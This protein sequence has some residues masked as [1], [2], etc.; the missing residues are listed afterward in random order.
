MDLQKQLKQDNELINCLWQI[1]KQAQIDKD[2]DTAL[3]RFSKIATASDFGLNMVMA[4]LKE[5]ER[6][7][8]ERVNALN[9]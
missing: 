3:D 6:R 4:M 9:G 7:E 8:K 2:W 5:L 1:F